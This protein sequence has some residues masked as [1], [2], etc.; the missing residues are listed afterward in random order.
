M[1]EISLTCD[2]LDDMLSDY[3]EG[4]LA[5]ERRVAIERHARDCSRCR[6][7]LGDLMAITREARALGPLMPS[8]DLW[9]EIA[10]RIEAPVVALSAGRPAR[11]R[12]L[13]RGPAALAAAAAALVIAT[14]S[15]TYLI[16][17]RQ[18]AAEMQ[19]V[20]T[21]PVTAVPV[22]RL[23]DREIARL[24][25]IVR[26]RRAAL[27]PA[28]AAVIERNLR[29]IDRAIAESRAALAKDP[30]SGLLN[31]QLNIALDRKVELLRTVALLPTGT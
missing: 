14:A 6:A 17:S 20:A 21:R 29:V 26:E 31:D 2:E 15:V 24:S 3:L 8:R 12:V 13:R 1:T 11:R 9:P 28:T 22:D 25:A 5:A 16:T 10:A 30:A 18:P 4:T 7:L 23:Y 27:D 19:P